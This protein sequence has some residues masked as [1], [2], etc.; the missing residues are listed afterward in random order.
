MDCLQ[1]AMETKTPH[2]KNRIVFH[3]DNERPHVQR[4]V[5][6][7]VAT[8][9]SGTAFISATFSQS[10]GRP[11]PRQSVAKNMQANKVCDDFDNLMAGVKACIASKN[12]KF[13]ARGI[14]RLPSNWEA[15]I[16]IDEVD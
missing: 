9:V 16:N 12:C 10:S 15:V 2:K 14:D 1:V 5:V 7:Y 11:L 13:F 3:H 8:K 4:R 6:E